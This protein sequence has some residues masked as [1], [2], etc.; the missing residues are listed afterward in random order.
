M[1]NVDGQADLSLEVLVKYNC[2]ERCD[3]VAKASVNNYYFNVPK[4]LQALTLGLF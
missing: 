2:T 4:L 1:A 3:V